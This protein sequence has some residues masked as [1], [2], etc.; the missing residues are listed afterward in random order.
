MSSK[1][2]LTGQ[3]AARYLQRTTP[4]ALLPPDAR[5]RNAAPHLFFPPF[6]VV[7][8]YFPPLTFAVGLVALS[9]PRTHSAAAGE[10]H[11]SL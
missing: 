7:S 1:Q 4:A 9:L 10:L 3:N 11:T 8:H 2:S 6:V 5:L